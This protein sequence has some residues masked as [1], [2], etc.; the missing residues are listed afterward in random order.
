MNRNVHREKIMKQK[1]IGTEINRILHGKLKT[2][3][4]HFMRKEIRTRQVLSRNEKSKI[5]CV[6]F[7]LDHSYMLEFSVQGRF[8]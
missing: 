3:R 6:K 5:D 4:T 8:I 7:F 1:G 2:R